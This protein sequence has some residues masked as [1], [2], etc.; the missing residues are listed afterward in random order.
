MATESGFINPPSSSSV[1]IEIHPL[2]RHST[3]QPFFKNTDDYEEFIEE[4]IDFEVKK[5]KLIFFATRARITRTGDLDV[6]RLINRAVRL[7]RQL[8]RGAN[9]SSPDY[10]PGRPEHKNDVDPNTFE[11]FFEPEKYVDHGHLFATDRIFNSKAELGNSAKETAMKVNTT[12]DRRPYVTLGCEH[13]GAN[14]PRTKLVVDDEEEVQ[15]KRRGPYGTKK[16]SCPFKLKG[17]Q[18][19]MCENWQVFVHDGRHNHAIGVYTHGHAQAA[20]LMEEQLIKT[21]QFKK[22]HVPPHN[23]LQFFQEQNVGCAVKYVALT[24][25][26]PD[27]MFRV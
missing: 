2:R 20:K 19:A 14:K 17:E 1:E 18:M 16:C 4:N 13:R 15:V 21:K 22:S 7:Q 25:M 8:P 6:H 24:L 12:S 3:S 26:H 23:I 10:R 9:R 5:F 27:F 11:E